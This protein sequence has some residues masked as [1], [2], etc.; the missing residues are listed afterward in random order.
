MKLTTDELIE[1]TNKTN[2]V[3]NK[4]YKAGVKKEAER[5]LPDSLFKALLD[6]GKKSKTLIDYHRSSDKSDGCNWIQL[7]PT[8]AGSKGTKHVEISF[9][10][11]KIEINGIFIAKED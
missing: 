5:E 4:A 7:K 8:R 11:N 3:M 2:D 6:Y 10:E 1:L 9:K